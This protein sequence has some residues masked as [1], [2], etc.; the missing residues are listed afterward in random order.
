M[1]FPRRHLTIPLPKFK[2]KQRKI[3]LIGGTCESA[4][5]AKEL[6]FAGLP[7]TISVTTDAAKSLYP[8]S[9]FLEIWVGKL[10]LSDIKSFLRIHEITAIVDA[11]HPYATEISQLAITV[12]SEHELP[13]L[14]YERPLEDREPE[15]P[16]HKN[17]P[18]SQTP[19]GN[20]IT[21]ENLDHL[22]QENYL[23]NQRVLLTLGYK[24][25][26][27]FLPWQDRATLFARILPS[28]TGLTAALASGFTPDRILA[29]RPPISANLEKALWEQWEISLVVAKSSGV[30]GGEGV[31]RA[32]AE[33]LGVALILLERPQ[34]SYPQQTND[35]SVAV[36]FCRYLFNN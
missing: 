7:C 36:E 13:Y 1:I 29:I 23:E 9:P 24:A 22:F 6:A 2:L 14:R 27:R 10:T 8:T 17:S 21:L 32:L 11:S 18:L 25:L 5:I 31:K 34:L 26:S 28:I 16:I 20:V 12:A 30:P 19:R 4:V 3:W 15:N 35:F 33:E